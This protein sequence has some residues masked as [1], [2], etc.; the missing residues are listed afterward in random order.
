MPKNKGFTREQI[1]EAIDNSDYTYNSVATYLAV[2]FSKSGKCTHDTAKSY[3]QK[4]NLEEYLNFKTTEI[5]KDC[6]QIIRKAIKKGDVKTAKWWLERVLREKFGNEIVIHNENKD[7]L[8]INLNGDFLSCKELKDSAMVDV[9][10]DE[11]ETDPSG[12]D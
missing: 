11:T 8:N 5:S 12:N 9:E 2:M 4:Y 7:P 1:I 3:I 6:I 10:N